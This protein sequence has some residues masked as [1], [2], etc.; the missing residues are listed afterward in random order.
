MPI[1]PTSW[2]LDE[3]RKHS[4]DMRQFIDFRESTLPNGMRIIDCYNSSGLTFTLL[5]DRGLDIWTAHYKG[6]PL[7]WISQGLVTPIQRRIVDHVRANAC[8][9]A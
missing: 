2:T 3:L 4:V 9:S 5:P 8:G 7:T 1:D 6:I